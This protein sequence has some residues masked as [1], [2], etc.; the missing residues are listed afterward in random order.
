[1]QIHYFVAFGIY[2]SIVACIGIYAAYKARSRSKNRSHDFLLGGRSTNWLLTSLSVH[3]A[4]M[5]DWLFMGLPAA[6]YLQGGYAC[7]IPVGLMVGMFLTWHY[8]AQR[9]RVSSQRYHAVTLASYFSARYGD[10]TGLISLLC[11][12]ISCFFF[13]IYLSVGL[14]GIGYVLQSAFA[15]DY[16]L[17][18]LIAVCVVLV[19]TMVGG[20]VSV[21]WIDL[22]QG[23]FLLAMLIVVPVYAF[24]Q[25]NGASSIVSAAAQ[26]H[27]SLSLLPDLSWSGIVT[28]LL[29]PCAWSLGYF[30]MPHILTKFMGMQH[31]EHMYK[32]KYVGLLWQ[33]CALLAAVGVGLVG[34][35]YFAFSPLHKA[36]FIFIALTQSLFQPWFAAI[37]LCAILAATISTVDSQLLVL[38]STWAHD[39]YK[40]R[41]YPQA[42][43]AHVMSVYRIALVVSA[44][45]GCMFA[46]NE[47]STIMG[48]VRYAWAGLGASFG[49]LLIVSLYSSYI[50]RAGAIGGI[51]AGALTTACWDT[52]QPYITDIPVYAIVPGYIASWCVM[53]TLSWITKRTYV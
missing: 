49:P 26:Q 29:N 42:S 24:F 19:Y 20:F 9:L 11:A 18:T 52:V 30:G 27:V 12:L 39:I 32:A 21:A 13:T 22:F 45:L 36:E 6:V 8:V 23:L 31:P 28:V 35:A 1:M 2:L 46:W 16:H 53:Y 43:T 17:G 5:S 4:D 15:L 44:G 38:A 3:A 51:I 25:G 7:W 40:Q 37:V 41:W 50:T 47:N 34:I 33:L 10:K 48:L 14:K